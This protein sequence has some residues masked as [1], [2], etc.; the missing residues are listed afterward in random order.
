MGKELGARIQI[1]EGGVLISREKAQKTQKRKMK[2]ISRK[3]D[4]GR[5][6]VDAG[7]GHKRSE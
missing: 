3:A 7:Q 6:P 4:F 1:Q 5:R 2:K